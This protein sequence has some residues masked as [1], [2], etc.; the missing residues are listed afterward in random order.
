MNKKRATVA[1]IFLPLFAL[2]V[3]VTIANAAQ[4]PAPSISAGGSNTCAV[5]VSGTVR[6]WGW[7]ETGVNDVPIDLGQVTQ[8]S[9]GRYH[10]CAVAASGVARCWGDNGWGQTDVPSDLGQVTQVSAGGYHT[11][12]VTVSNAVRCWGNDP[13]GHKD[14]PSDLGQVT[15][16][17]VGLYHVCAVAASGVARCWGDNGWGQ[18]DVPSDLGQVTQVSAG[19]QHTCAVNFSGAVRCWGNNLWFGQT[20]VPSDLGQAKQVSAV[21]YHTCAVTVSNAVRCWGNNGHGR[22]DVPSDLGQVTQVSAGG[23]HTCAVTISGVARC[24]GNN[25]SGQSYLPPG[26]L[27]LPSQPVLSIFYSTSTTIQLTW[28]APD[29]GAPTDYVIE[30]SSD[31]GKSW[32]IYND[33]VSRSP[34]TEVKGLLNG[35]SYLFRVAALS[36]IGQGA[37][38]NIVSQKTKAFAVQVTGILKSGGTAKALVLSF[39]WIPGSKIT[40]QWLLDG[41]K[42]SGKTASTLKVLKSYVG[43]KISVSATCKAKG[44]ATLVANSL[45]V[46]A[47][48]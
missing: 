23:Q 8:V 9:A 12:A 21:G 11:C 48:K 46:K 2:L 41:K 47:L 44:Y 18:T 36:P 5:T 45:A 13:Y 43:R 29:Y 22:T 7:N 20:D 28:T 34:T 42:I 39:N 3:P 26:F 16:V 17:S 4:A 40:F 38:S 31:K 6:C 30:Y 24:W 32:T 27:S 35:T 1:A 15:Q 14:V 10:G 37:Y 33:R 19:V 25:N